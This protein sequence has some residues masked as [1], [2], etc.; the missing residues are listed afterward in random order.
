MGRKEMLCIPMV[1]QTCQCVPC[2][3]PCTP[4]FY[5]NWDK[6]LP[7]DTGRSLLSPSLI[8]GGTGTGSGL[9]GDAFHV[10][11]LCNQH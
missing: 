9:P 8:G 3:W 1:P 10:F 7:Q 6:H 5:V 2:P 4:F 11:A